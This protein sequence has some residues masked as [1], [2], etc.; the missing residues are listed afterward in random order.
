MEREWFSDLQLNLG[1]AAEPS[2]VRYGRRFMA[3]RRSRVPRAA[4]AA[5]YGRA[6]PI[7]LAVPGAAESAAGT[8]P[9][10]SIADDKCAAIGAKAAARLPCQ[11]PRM[12]G[13]RALPV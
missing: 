2:L 9:T 1:G 5:K 4:A 7:A 3:R 10:L 13:G 11:A 6:K 12:H 8:I